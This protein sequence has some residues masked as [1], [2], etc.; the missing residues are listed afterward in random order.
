MKNELNF[1]HTHPFMAVRRK[2]FSDLQKKAEQSPWKDMKQDARK[3][4]YGL[5]FNPDDCYIL[6]CN[7]VCDIADAAALVSILEP[8][9]RKQCVQKLLDIIRLW[10]PG[11]PGNLY[12]EMYQSS[13]DHWVGAIPPGAAFVNCLLALDILYDDLTKEQ[14]LFCE[15]TLETIAENYIQNDENHMV[16]ILGVR[17]LWALYKGRKEQLFQA[18][19]SWKELFMSYITEDGAG[20]MSIDYSVDR[21][22]RGDRVSKVILP[23]VMDFTGLDRSFYQDQKVIQFAEWALG[24]TYTP[25][26][27]MWLIGDT[28]LTTGVKEAESL[29]LVYAAAKYSKK[30]AEFAAW[31]MKGRTPQGKLLNYLLL[32]E[33]F[34]KPR[35]PESQILKDGGAW[36]YENMEEKDSL[37]GVLWNSTIF[38]G[39]GHKEI[40][41][42]SLAAYGH[43]LYAN[44]GYSGWGSGA[45]G[46]TWNYINQ[47]ALSANTV[48]VDYDY[49]NVFNPEEKNDHQLKNGAGIV[50]GFTSEKLCYALGNS[51]SALPN[52]VHRRGLV[53]VA[54]EDGA[55]GYFLL[56]DSVDAGNK[57]TV[58]HRPFSDAYKIEKKDIEYVWKVGNAGLSIFLATPPSDTEI[59]DGIVADRISYL[60]M[61]FQQ[62]HVGSKIK[63]L[64]AS[65]SAGTLA[66]T[67]LFPFDNTHKKPIL[68]RTNVGMKFIYP[69]QE[70]LLLTTNCGDGET[71]F[72]GA[73][74]LV[75]RTDSGCKWFFAQ[76][77]VG[78]NCMGVGFHSDRPVSI[79]FD[80]TEGMY[81]A[82]EDTQFTLFAYSGE[83][84]VLIGT[85][86]PQEVKKDGGGISFLLPAGTNSIRLVK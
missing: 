32:K 42:V 53:M 9:L 26:K 80:G 44:A 84:A 45:E 41:S 28:L 5:H 86:Q 39:H 78:L 30:A 12:D 27:C 56:L 36:F 79:F 68:Q 14:R 74:A 81:T 70:D 16:A 18:W 64:L 33:D 47:R 43:R 6:R 55:P 40:N 11:V 2:Q 23:I 21:F 4:F 34:E 19:E 17:G 37:A 62:R 24:Y 67:V 76:L 72:N 31:L 46:F 10:Q 15:Q 54:G 35:A 75:R 1:N 63:S 29:F 50:E 13:G 20:V 38:D 77:A 65:Y 58:V 71:R 8:P 69:Y 82:A 25:A 85:E 48:L 61:E 22:V 60:N 52:A 59:I 73:C 51:G 7:S 83:T 66:A 57:M 49:H 3:R